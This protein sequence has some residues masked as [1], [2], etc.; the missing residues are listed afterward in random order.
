[1]YKN[2]NMKSGNELTR[3]ARQEM[4]NRALS[5]SN[6]LVDE[7]MQR[8]ATVG[9]HLINYYDMTQPMSTTISTTQ[10]LFLEKSFLSGNLVQDV[11]L[12]VS[13]L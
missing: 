13:M 12:A 3:D 7:L 10:Q 6:Y 1:M 8:T 11:C 2:E 4:R 9:E 5:S